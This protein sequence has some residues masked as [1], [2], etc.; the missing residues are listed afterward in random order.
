MSAPE[1]ARFSAAVESLPAT[2]PLP[3][4]RQITAQVVDIMDEEQFP[5]FAIARADER[6]DD[7]VGRD[8]SLVER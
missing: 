6:Y 4:V 3:R 1:L 7:P 5:E 2:K 8:L